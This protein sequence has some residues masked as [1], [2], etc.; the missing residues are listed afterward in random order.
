[1]FFCTS[2]IPIGSHEKETELLNKLVTALYNDHPMIRGKAA[3][4][5]GRFQFQPSVSV[6]ALRRALKDEAIWQRE[7]N[8]ISWRREKN[9]ISVRNAAI[10]S[11][12]MFGKD[13][14]DAVPDIIQLLPKLSGDD[15]VVALRTLGEIGAGDDKV[16]IILREIATDPNYSTDPNTN[17]AQNEIML[18]AIDGLGNFGMDDPRVREIL[19]SLADD[20][21]ESIRRT[22]IRNFHF[23]EHPDKEIIETLINAVEDRSKRVRLSAL[24]GLSSLKVISEDI[25][26]KYINAVKD[27][28]P[29]V[30]RDAVRVLSSMKT[31]SSKI[32]NALQYAAKDNNPRVREKAKQALRKFGCKI[33]D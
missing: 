27:E 23:V 32:E 6:P 13:A 15:K 17:K 28:S 2:Q 11:L 8:P 16:F 10:T 33:Q 7:I 24:R 4:I 19:F 20:E 14:H 26:N 1:M 29:R 3:D 18:A 25:V 30:R 5:V 21:S 9:P 22:S 31:V 12:G